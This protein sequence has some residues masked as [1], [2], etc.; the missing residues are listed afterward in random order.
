MNILR[1]T[2]ALLVA[3]GLAACGGSGDGNAVDAGARLC[4]GSATGGG[5][6]PAVSRTTA[7]RDQ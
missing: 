1:T 4:Q 5:H 3:G 6:A 2:V 7:A